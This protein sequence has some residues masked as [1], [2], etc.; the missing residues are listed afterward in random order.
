[1]NVANNLGC[2][3]EE[4]IPLKQGL[5][6]DCLW[7]KPRRLTRDEEQI[8][9]KQGLKLSNEKQRRFLQED[10]EQIPLKQG[11]K[12]ITFTIGSIRFDQMKSKFH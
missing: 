4:Q 1:M 10:E 3:D 9:L 5:K 8:P 7:L 6:P 11:L 2:L 12:Q